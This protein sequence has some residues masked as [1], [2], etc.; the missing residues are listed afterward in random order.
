MSTAE[1]ST[2][3]D[4]ELGHYYPGRFYSDSSSGIPYEN[5]IS[6][7]G[8]RGVGRLD[9]W[10]FDGEIRGGPAKTA[11]IIVFLHETAHLV[12]DLSLGACIELDNLAD[13]QLAALLHL[14][15][16]TRN[17]NP[18]SCPLVSIEEGLPKWQGPETA[19]KLGE[20]VCEKEYLIALLKGPHSELPA[21][22]IPANPEFF[23]LTEELSQLSAEALM[24]GLVAVKTSFAM[25]MRAKEED[26]IRYLKKWKDLLP[27]L[28]EKLP[29]FYMVARHIFD[30]TL[31]VRLGFPPEDYR[32][33]WPSNYYHSRRAICDEGFMYLA[34]LALHVPPL[35]WAN[36]R[37]AKGL[38]S[39]T[40]F[41]PAYRFV[42]A[43]DAIIKRGG[44]PQRDPALPVNQFYKTVFDCI[45]KTYSWPTYVETHALWSEKL[46]IQKERRQEAVDGYRNRLINEKYKNPANVAISDCTAVCARNSIPILHLTPQ[47]A[48]LIY[49][50]QTEGNM[51][52][53]IPFEMP[54]LDAFGI[55]GTKLPLW[56]NQP[57]KPTAEA[58]EIEFNNRELFRQEMVFRIVCLTLADAM[59]HQSCFKCPMSKLG[60]EVAT[61]ACNELHRLDAIPSKRCCVRLYAECKDLDLSRLSWP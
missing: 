31:G 36:Q 37:M 17:T 52:Y 2:L 32:D 14:A 50:I 12:H 60:C 59:L 26:D 11:R 15:R 49:G 45:A 22:I 41:I 4:V 16:R 46:S 8:A 18:F 34:D 30:S 43:I 21:C 25:T 23:P 51:T 5:D 3:H 57:D 44:F 10:S 28:P 54:D 6:Y 33:D 42:M 24:E 1:A 39:P 53:S 35:E 20:F 40:D 58:F 61:P 19:E 29:P 56:K 9:S 38:N 55:M 13:A 7:L 48:K 47:G 27:L